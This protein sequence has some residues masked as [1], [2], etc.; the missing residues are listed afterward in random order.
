M[1]ADIIAESISDEADYR[2]YIREIT[3]EEGTLTSTAKDEKS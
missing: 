2:A 1:P 3:M